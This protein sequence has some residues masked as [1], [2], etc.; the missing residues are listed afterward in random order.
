MA[1]QVFIEAEPRRMG[2]REVRFSR[3]DGGAVAQAHG[4]STPDP[5]SPEALLAA[6]EAERKNRAWLESRLEELDKRLV[7][8][9]AVEKAL[10]TAGAQEQLGALAFAAE[11]AP[12]RAKEADREA[13][14]MWILEAQIRAD[15]AEPQPLLPVR[16]EPIQVIRDPVIIRETVTVREAV[17]DA[18]IEEK[19][20]SARLAVEAAEA[21]A[22]HNAAQVRRLTEELAGARSEQMRTLNRLKD[23]E[24]R[25][26]GLESRAEL[27]DAVV[28]PKVTPQGAPQLELPADQMAPLHPVTP[29][30]VFTE[31]D[32]GTQLA[33]AEPEVLDEAP[34]LSLEDFEPKPRV[35]APLEEETTAD[36][37]LALEELEPVAIPQQ[38]EAPAAQEPVVSEPAV[39]EPETIEALAEPEGHSLVD[40]FTELFGEEEPAKPKAT[41]AA[42]AKDAGELNDLAE[43]FEMWGSGPEAA[44]TA[45]VAEPDHAPAPAEE[46][47]PAAASNAAVSN[48]DD[49]FGDLASALESL[50]DAPLEP[51]ADEAPKQAVEEEDAFGA[52]AAAVEQL[53]SAPIEVAAREADAVLV[54]ERVEEMAAPVEHAPVEAVEEELHETP[55]PEADEA[56]D[57]DGPAEEALP[58]RSSGLRQAARGRIAAQAPARARQDDGEEAGATPAKGRA[59]MVDALL[60]F[61]GPQ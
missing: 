6:L 44:P 57:D 11:H 51:P 31:T 61:M 38:L 13:M 50:S 27:L 45:K 23:M 22:A 53:E 49:P 34:A 14:A 60:K 7:Q 39:S 1:I 28:A 46:P 55:A 25:L 48:Y 37:A 20:A 9:L 43:A 26:L 30:L 36:G 52:L 2:R 3:P 24:K 32:A 5:T 29:E 56:P 40:A 10:E 59:A 42:T 4:G 35:L 41:P 15:A 21:R 47:K 16:Q 17:V 8:A 18:R 58:T 19:I 33:P 54:E 12:A